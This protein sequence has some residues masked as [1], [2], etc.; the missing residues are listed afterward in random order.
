MDGSDAESEGAVKHLIPILD[1]GVILDRG[2][3]VIVLLDGMGDDETKQQINAILGLLGIP[4]RVERHE[5][6]EEGA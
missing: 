5:L 3:H 4:A 2:D 1:E 6:T